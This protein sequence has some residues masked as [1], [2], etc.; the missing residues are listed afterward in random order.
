MAD[1]TPQIIRKALT[2]RVKYTMADPGVMP[3]AVFVLLYPK[4]GQYCLLLNKRSQTV[5]HHKGEI[6]FPGGMRDPEDHDFLQTAFREA[7]EEMGIEPT[8]ITLLGELD[9]V[10]TRTNFGIRV[11]IGTIPYPYPFQPSPMEVAEVLE[12][13][14]S[15]LLDPL[16]RRQETRWVDGRPVNACSYGYQEHLIFGATAKILQQFLEILEEGLKD[17][18]LKQN[19]EGY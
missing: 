1:S 7:R 2:R 18:A 14:I 19:K 6:S 12:V 9:D 11:F 16:N 8:H 17:E 10:V 5:E 4:D 13:P 3:A 15:A